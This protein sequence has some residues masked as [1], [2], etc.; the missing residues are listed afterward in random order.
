MLTAAGFRLAA[1]SVAAVAALPFADFRRPPP[2]EWPAPQPPLPLRAGLGAADWPPLRESLR[3]KW[4]RIIGPFP[5]RPAGPG[6][7]E[8]LGRTELPDHTRLHLR[9]PVEPGVSAEAYLLLPKGEFRG[10]R[11]G[12]VVLHATSKTHMQ[13]PVGLSGRE[14]MHLALHLVRRGYVCV[15]PRNYLWADPDR[16]YQQAAE[17]VL[18]RPPWKTGMARM[19]WDALRATDILAARPEVDPRRLGSIGHSLGGKETLYHAAFD[20]RIRA[21][22]SCEGGIGRSFSNWDADWYLGRQIRSP[23]FAA[24]HHEVLALVA[25]RAFLQIGGE[26]ADGKQSWPYIAACLPVWGLFG[27]EVRLGLM[28]HAYGH[29]FLPPGA[30]RERVWEWLDHQMRD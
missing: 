6:R 23:E 3:A 7:A 11:P 27:A 30:E 12:M 21:T 5:E 28:R 19:T 16:T 22:V 15:A 2:G 20:A 4:Q 18:A 24:D 29:D 17:A 13:D 25:P 9:Y 10:P 1:V 14:A 26:S 8:E